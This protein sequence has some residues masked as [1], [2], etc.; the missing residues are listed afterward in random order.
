MLIE[1]LPVMVESKGKITNCEGKKTK[2]VMVRFPRFTVECI[3][4]FTGD[5]HSS[6]P[7]FVIDAVRQYIPHVI[8]DAATAITEM[9]GVNVSHQAKDVFFYERMSESMFPEAESY[10]KSKDSSPKGQDISVLVSMPVGLNQMIADV[11]EST[12]LFSSNQELIKTAVHW[13]IN[14]MNDVKQGLELVSGFRFA[15]DNGRSLE[16]EL[17]QIRRELSDFRRVSSER[18]SFSLFSSILPSYEWPR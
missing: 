10:R 6:R 17:E 15:K 2:Q 12:G 1:I 14:H 13:M 3:D 5:T 7:D 8:C 9:E 16:R 18:F 11:V 4:D